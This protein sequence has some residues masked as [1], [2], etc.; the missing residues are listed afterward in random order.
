VAKGPNTLFSE[1]TSRYQVRARGLRRDIARSLGLVLAFVW[2]AIGLAASS[3]S[4]SARPLIAVPPS[5]EQQIRQPCVLYLCVSNPTGNLNWTNTLGDLSTHYCDIFAC[6]PMDLVPNHGFD[7]NLFPLNPDWAFKLQAGHAPDAL[8]LCGGFPSAK[9]NVPW[10]PLGQPPCTSQPTTLDEPGFGT[11]AQIACPYGR[12]PYFDSI[13]GHYN[14]EPATYEGTL[15]WDEAIGH[16]PPGTDDEYSLGLTTDNLDGATKSNP[17][18]IHIEFDSDETIDRFQ[19]PWWEQFHHAVDAHNGS[20]GPFVQGHLAEVTGLIGLDTAHDPAAESHPV[21]SLAIQT[22]RSSALAGK[23]DRWAIFARTWGNEGYCSDDNHTLPPGPLTVRIP[24]LD[25]SNGIRP[26]SVIGVRVLG[27]SSFHTNLDNGGIRAAVIPNKGVLITFDLS[28]KAS[29]EPLYDGTVDLQWI[30]GPPTNVPQ[31]IQR[32]VTPRGEDQ[33]DSDVEP[34]VGRLWKH[35]P[36][37]TR[38]RA[39]AL[40]PN[41][42]PEPDT[43]HVRI[44]MTEAPTAPLRK[45]DAYIP[46]RRD[47]EVNARG[48]AQRRAL[49]RAYNSHVPRYR[50][51]C[52]RTE[53]R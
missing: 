46:A 11:M 20:A 39:L 25:N 2:V 37:R 3:P 28:A 22:N 4:A 29:S 27:S 38:R 45:A 21:Y 43:K 51:P 32:P 35:L 13:H 10:F 9:P 44:V 34:S 31:T 40:L 50:T 30:L 53:R 36:S 33:E 12:H 49:C 6:S 41:P 24:W 8:Q 42:H 15:T 17:D 16:S 52:P 48:K 14:W 18:G 1:R 19:T 26:N 47:H 5:L 23:I 7:D